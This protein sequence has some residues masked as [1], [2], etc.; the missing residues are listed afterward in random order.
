MYA[1]ND[2]ECTVIVGVH[3]LYVLPGDRGQRVSGPA[4]AGRAQHFSYGSGINLGLDAAAAG[5]DFFQL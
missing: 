2:G 3:F 1:Y 5:Y 4:V